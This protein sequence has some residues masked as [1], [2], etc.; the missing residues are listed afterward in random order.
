MQ[1]KHIIIIAASILLCVIVAAL[2]ITSYQKDSDWQ[3]PDASIRF[4]DGGKYDIR[5][6][7]MDAEEVYVFSEKTK[8]D[9]QVLELRLQK[10]EGEWDGKTEFEKQQD[11]AED[12]IEPN[13]YLDSV[14][15]KNSGKKIGKFLDINAYIVAVNDE[16]NDSYE[17]QLLFLVSEEYIDTTGEN[18]DFISIRGSFEGEF[19]ENVG[20]ILER[21]YIL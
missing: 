14:V 6:S 20:E 13:N 9:K 21:A 17:G 11:L 7:K 12:S 5:F 1:K 15:S 4:K 18:Q 3:H 16:A 2:A 19:S 10:R 8:G